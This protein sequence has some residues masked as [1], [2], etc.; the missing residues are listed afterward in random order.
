MM[1]IVIM[2]KSRN[3]SVNINNISDNSLN[4]I[5]DNEYNKTIELGSNDKN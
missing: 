3:N 4:D 5:D 2:M 1:K